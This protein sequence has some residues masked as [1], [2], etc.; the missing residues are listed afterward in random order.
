MALANGQK[1]AGGTKDEKVIYT[2]AKLQELQERRQK[3]DCPTRLQERSPE[4]ART[5]TRH[6]SH[7][8]RVQ[9][10]EVNQ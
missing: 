9:A 1:N 7:Q 2:A 10:R 3:Q 6:A 5:A 4:H 8:V